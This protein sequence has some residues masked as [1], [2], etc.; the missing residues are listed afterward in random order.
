MRPPAKNKV[1]MEFYLQAWAT[2]TAPADGAALW[3]III[4]MIVSASLFVALIVLFTR[5]QQVTREA[6]KGFSDILAALNAI[7]SDI[8]IGDNSLMGK[9]NDTYQNLNERI[10]NAKEHVLSHLQYIRDRTK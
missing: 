6:I 8:Q 1:A 4:L 9:M 2:N 10:E 3:L 5:Y 7:R